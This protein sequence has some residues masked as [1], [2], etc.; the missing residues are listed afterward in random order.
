MAHKIRHG[1]GASRGSPR[2]RQFGYQ[3]KTAEPV[4]P[5]KLTFPQRQGRY[6]ELRLLNGIM[7]TI[8][9]FWTLSTAK[10]VSRE[11]WLTL[12]H[13]VGANT[14]R[15]LKKQFIEEWLTDTDDDEDDLEVLVPTIYWAQL[16]WFCSLD[17]PRTEADLWSGPPLFN[18][19]KD[20]PPSYPPISQAG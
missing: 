10:N 2:V 13:A 15:R 16:R 1:G 3:E 11:E 4:V 5:L 17:I 14:P 9:T 12:L 7:N 8:I 20:E 19:F 6:A 18:R